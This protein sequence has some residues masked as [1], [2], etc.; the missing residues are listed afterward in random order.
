MILTGIIFAFTPIDNYGTTT[1]TRS[2]AFGAD[3]YTLEYE[4]TAAAAK[5]SA[6]AARNIV[7]FSGKIALYFGF[8][9]V[10]AGALVIL[11][12][13]SASV[14]ADIPAQPNNEDKRIA[15]EVVSTDNTS[16]E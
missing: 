10:F 6:S 16:N 9:F 1:S 14:K 13:A 3:F 4:A 8:A 12:Y 5:N 7:A 15:S 11:H 2:A